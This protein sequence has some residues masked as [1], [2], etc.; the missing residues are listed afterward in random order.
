[1]KAAVCTSEV[2]K[3]GDCTADGACCSGKSFFNG[4]FYC[5]KYKNAE[6]RA[7]LMNQPGYKDGKWQCRPSGNCDTSL[8]PCDM[9]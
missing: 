3:W 4:D 7:W 5:T 8:E 9:K 2:A 6:G 1:M